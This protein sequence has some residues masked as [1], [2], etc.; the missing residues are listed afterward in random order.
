MVRAVN[1]ASITARLTDDH[2]RG[3]H[4]GRGRKHDLCVHCDR[5]AYARLGMQG[6]WQG[7]RNDH[8]IAGPLFVGGVLFLLSI[9]VPLWGGLFVGDFGPGLNRV[10]APLLWPLIVVGVIT[11]YQL[12][13]RERPVWAS[14]AFIAPFALNLI[15]Q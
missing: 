5:K 2:A 4:R 15:A 7:T 10:I 12:L 1:N 6:P 13:K 9:G 14:I 8:V 11:S 3:Y